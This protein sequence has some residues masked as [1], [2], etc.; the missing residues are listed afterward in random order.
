[1]R[2]GK[3]PAWLEVDG[4]VIGISL[5]ADYCAEHEWGINRLK[6]TLGVDGWVPGSS[7]EKPKYT[8]PHGLP[9][10]TISQHDAVRLYEHK[11]AAVLLCMDRWRYESFDKYIA[12]HGIARAFKER[13]PQDLPRREL[14]TAWSEDDFGIYG[15]GQNADRIKDLYA[16]FQANNVGIWIGGRMIAFENGGLI[17]CIADRIPAENSAMLAEADIESEKLQ[18][19][20]DATGIVERLNKAGKR[21]FSCSP[22]WRRED[23]KSA[24]PVV[25]W[26]NP[27]DQDVNNFGW[28]TVE[29][30]D[31]WIAGA[32]PVPM[33]PVA[34]R[35][36]G[37]SR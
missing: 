7:R 1:M 30:L 14:G 33:D 11:E 16:A 21:F 20:S 3:Q 25:Y 10:R 13:L 29:E 12:E 18:A 6:R 35:S 34:S 19:A 23:R 37:S 2:T 32:G 4:K 8:K 26:L 9:R 15:Q 31:Q 17:L 27:M 5:G 22:K 28:F 36:R 24:H